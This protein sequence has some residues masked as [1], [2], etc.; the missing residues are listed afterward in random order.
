M[1]LCVAVM[2]ISSS[3]STSG[4][5]SFLN[6]TRSVTVER[7][8]PTNVRASDIIALTHDH[9]RY[10]GLQPLVVELSRVNDGSSSPPIPFSESS[11]NLFG[12]NAQYMPWNRYRFREK[13]AWYGLTKCDLWLQDTPDGINS[14]VEA[15]G[16]VQ[17]QV[18]FKAVET[19]QGTH[20]MERASLTGNAMMMPLVVK[21]YTEAHEKMITAVFEEVVRRNETGGARLA[22]V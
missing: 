19:E 9:E 7:L 1:L 16:G 6:T 3:A 15:S 8:L 4:T 12:E 11:L 2:R 5:M 13:I 22:F 21:S 18:N 14:Y 17:L 20:I 10:I